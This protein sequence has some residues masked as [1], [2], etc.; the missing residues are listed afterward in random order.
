MGFQKLIISIAL[1][2][3]F[4][5]SVFMFSATFSYQNDLNDSL[6]SQEGMS[7]LNSS[8][9]S[10]L[11]NLSTQADTTTNSYIQEGNNPILTSFGFY[12]RSMLVGGINF[13]KIATNSMGA[14]FISAQ[15]NLGISPLVVSLL[16]AILGIVL[17]LTTWRLWRAGE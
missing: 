5:V 16:S 13:L 15:T 9:S 2:T 8:L 3:L 11:T 17:V 14:L 10:E 6:I 4:I 7:L 1:M 12:F